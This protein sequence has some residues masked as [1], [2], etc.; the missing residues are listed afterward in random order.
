LE[1]RALNLIPVRALRERQRDIRM[2]GQDVPLLS[3]CFLVAKLPSWTSDQILIRMSESELLK[4][5][6]KDRLVS[7]ASPVAHSANDQGQ[8]HDLAEHLRETGS[9]SED[10]T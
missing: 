10:G 1:T 8:P 7:V 6:F 5:S 2:I 3:R 4:T 9:N